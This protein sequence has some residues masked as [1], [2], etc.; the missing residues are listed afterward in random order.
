M[1][2]KGGGTCAAFWG[3]GWWHLWAE[4][5]ACGCRQSAGHVGWGLVGVDVPAAE[6]I[7]TY[8]NLWCAHNW[9]LAR[10]RCSVVRKMSCHA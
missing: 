5:R 6:D 4:G 3:D 7:L 2:W 8:K 1:Q 10:R 9:Y